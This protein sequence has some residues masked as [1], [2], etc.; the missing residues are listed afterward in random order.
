MQN[1]ACLHIWLPQEGKHLFSIHCTLSLRQD[2]ARTELRKRNRKIQKK[3]DVKC[4]N[5]L[6]R[7]KSR[8]Q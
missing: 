2:M 7:E 5:L 8:K 1:H 6:K 4:Q 3:K